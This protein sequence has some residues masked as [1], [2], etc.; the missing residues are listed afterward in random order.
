ME[1][2]EK[3][4]KNIELLDCTLRDGGH[5]T[6]SYFGKEV[7]AD[8]INKLLESRI[9]IIEA[10][11]LKDCEFDE[12]VACYNNIEEAMRVLPP[13]T[14]DVRYSLM[15]QEDLY[16][17]SKL[18]DYN[19]AV[20]II[21]V[22][23]HD[24]DLDEGLEF[25]RKIVEKG[26]QCY[27]NPINVLGYTDEQLIE[28]IRRV[29]VI[30][31]EG[32]TIVDT[33]GALK[34]ED[35]LRIYYLIDHNLSERVKISLHLHENQSMSFSLAQTFIE[36]RSAKRNI[37]IDGSLYGMG[38][39]PGNLCIELIMNYMN[40]VLGENY[41]IEP[42]YDAIDEYI[43]DI[44]RK[45]PWGYSSAYAL[46]AQHNLHRTY[47]EYLLEKGKLRT[48][49]I[50]QILS[51][52][53]GEHKTI[54]DKSYIENLYKAY[55]EHGIE[56]MSAIQSLQ[57]QIAGKHI[58]LLAPGKSIEQNAQQV[59]AAMKAADICLSADF[60][61]EKMNCDY[62]FCSNI[63]R[64]DVYG[65]RI[66]GSK[67]IITSNLIDT[68]HPYD[69]VINYADYAYSYNQLFDNCGVMLLKLVEKLGAKELT[70][71]GYDGFT[72]SHN[73]AVT[74]MEREYTASMEEENHITAKVIADMRERIAIQF[75]TPS[76][77]EK[78]TGYGL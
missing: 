8:V 57:E 35:L 66:G 23:F 38:R 39:V 63:K 31:P 40:Q 75:V 73:F 49:Q 51:M 78:G 72:S 59:I 4:F 61:W 36:I 47:A 25:A 12:D 50:N 60:I 65:K 17:L 34:K 1:R 33:F 76:I 56:D 54:F 77:Y 20:D 71:A 43:M 30:Q 28:I 70:L 21:R 29:N 10:G 64:W 3:S 69:F 62:L 41:N 2:R 26:Y 37:C 14:G 67:K 48:K 68:E 74:G 16:D 58:L 19:G 5:L 7:I 27:I 55:Q 42:V 53:D 44:K 15:A 18:E 52:I 46:S 13:K 24:F 22:S 11:F 6:N 32:F 9:D 45:I